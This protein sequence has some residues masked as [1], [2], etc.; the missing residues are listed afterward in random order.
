MFFDP[1]VFESSWTEARRNYAS[2]M[3]PDQLGSICSLHHGVAIK[4]RCDNPSRQ[5]RGDFEVMS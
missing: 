3:L 1:D 5:S 4:E 2:R